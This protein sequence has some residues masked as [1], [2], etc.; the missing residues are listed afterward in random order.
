[1]HLLRKIYCIIPLIQ[2]VSREVKS[3]GSICVDTNGWSS[4]G[5]E[6]T[7]MLMSSDLRSSPH[8]LG[9]EKIDL[10]L[11]ESMHLPSFW[12]MAPKSDRTYWTE[13]HSIWLKTA[14]EFGF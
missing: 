11:L 7:Y 6:V 10:V 12:E 2:Q 4:D 1:M 9:G 14:S 5:K 3:M 13:T 8:L